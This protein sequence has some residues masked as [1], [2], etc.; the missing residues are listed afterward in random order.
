MKKHIAYLKKLN[1]CEDAVEWAAEFTTLQKAWDVCER[2]DWMVWMIAKQSGDPESKSR[3][4]LVLLLCGIVRPVLKFVPEDE[5]R[6]LIAIETMEKWVRGEASL[7]DVRDAASAA[8]AAYAVSAAASAS[9]V[10]VPAVPRS[11]GCRYV[12]PGSDYRV[13]PPAS[14]HLG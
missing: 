14:A 13:V 5:K 1:A 9:S 8:Y 6:P 7:Q 11:L 2:G 4:K 3:K 10:L 12:H